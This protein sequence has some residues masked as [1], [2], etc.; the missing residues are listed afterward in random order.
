MAA[1]YTFATRPPYV[2]SWLNPQVSAQNMM[3][4]EMLERLVLN[5]FCTIPAK[6]LVQL[7]TVFQ[8]GGLRNRSKTFIYKDHLN[9]SK[10]PILA[11]AGD[12]DLIC[13]PEAVY[14]T[15]KVVPGRLVKFKVFGEPRGP[16]YAHYDLV[17]GHLAPKEVYPCIVEFL[18][19]HDLT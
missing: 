3:Q 14:E 15:V 7:R 18:Q 12:K 4:P 8:E 19:H 13:P 10:V 16:H 9:K 11:L 5:N 2:L 6:L 17:G 1:A